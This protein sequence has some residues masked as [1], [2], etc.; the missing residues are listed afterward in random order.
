MKRGKIIE[1]RVLGQEREEK[2]K[3]SKRKEGKEYQDRKEHKER[4]E[5]KKGKNQRDERKQKKES[6][7]KRKIMLEIWRFI[8]SRQRISIKAKKAKFPFV[9]KK[10]NSYKCENNRVEKC[11]RLDDVE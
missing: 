3:E 7:N 5:R 8:I 11:L 2:R 6:K 4:K 1:E 10:K 9:G